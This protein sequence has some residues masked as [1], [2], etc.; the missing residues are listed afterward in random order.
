MKQAL[1]AAPQPETTPS[2]QV[3][4]A[5]LAAAQVVS[6]QPSI[7]SVGQV[8]FTQHATSAHCAWQPIVFTQLSWLITMHWLHIVAFGSAMMQASAHALS[9]QPSRQVAVDAAQTGVELE[10]MFCGRGELAVQGANMPPPPP[11][12]VPVMPGPASVPVMPG[13]KLPWLQH[14][15]EPALLC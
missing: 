5:E 10:A 12:S 2:A 1:I 4:H 13:P 15:W 11:A 3:S 14:G 7:M 6:M 9:V 8:V